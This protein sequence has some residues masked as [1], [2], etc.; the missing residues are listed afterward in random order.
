MF[1]S[2][3]EKRLLSEYPKFTFI[4]YD[5][6]GYGNDYTVEA[7]DITFNE[8][9]DE[10][11]QVLSKFSSVVEHNR[12]AIEDLICKLKSTVEENRFI[13]ELGLE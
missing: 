9:T 8:L 1:V 11:Y 4:L 6:A 12:F 3:E 2:P 13:H 10:E 7:G 5:W